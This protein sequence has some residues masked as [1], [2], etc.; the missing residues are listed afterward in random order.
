MLRLRR[1]KKVFT[2]VDVQAPLLCFDF[3]KVQALCEYKKETT[4]RYVDS[5]PE[6]CT[7]VREQPALLN[8]LLVEGEVGHLLPHA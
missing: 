5:V 3:S 6:I 2:K 8:C 7:E 4:R 1:L